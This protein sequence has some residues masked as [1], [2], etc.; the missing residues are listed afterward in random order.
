V[1]NA[2]RFTGIVLL[3]L[4]V[5]LIAALTVTAQDAMPDA[6][7]VQ[8]Q[9]VASGFNRP[10]L[11]THAGDG[12]GRLFVVEQ[13]GLIKVIQD[14]QVLETPFLDVASL[15][16]RDVFGNGFSERGLL[17]LAF[18]PDYAT[19]GK[20]YID[21]TDVNGNT[22]I[23]QYTV[24][25]DDPNVADPNSAITVLTQEQ[26]YANHNGGH[27]SF[28]PDGYLYIAFGDGGGGS[29]PERNGQNPATLLA[30]IS[31]I[32]VQDDGTY[33][34]PEDNPVNGD[35]RFAPEVWA[36]GLRNPWRFS[37]DAA[38][39]D[40]YIGDVGQNQLE[41]INFEPADS[42]GGV[43]YGWSIFEASQPYNGG[44]QTDDMVFPVAEYGRGQGIS[45]TGGYVYRGAALPQLDG[46]YFYGDFGLGTI[47]ALWR[48]AAGDWQHETFLASGA[49]ISS[50]GVDEQ[51]ELYVVNYAGSI[52]KFTP[53]S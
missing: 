43:N 48:D 53:A 17:G 33:T 47:W 22:V 32:N 23:A 12:S 27:L 38:T 8:L 6:A 37:F 3:T 10:L 14:G 50:F 1:R 36:Y 49:T 46:I 34:I 51:N 28:G 41:E 29:D 25:T 31:R 52:L 7:G 18:D 5:T 19:N 40:L 24:S 9:E 11:V 44:D 13:T 4:I 26:P 20:F 15:L 21:Y 35:E 30:T 45:V 42:A 16:H 39:G 2:S